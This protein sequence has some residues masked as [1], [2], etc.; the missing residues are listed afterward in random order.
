[1][2]R[3]SR[4]VAP[5]LLALLLGV[6]L[7]PDPGA[8]S[9][10]PSSSLEDGDWSDSDES[11]LDVEEDEEPEWSGRVPTAAELL[12]LDSVEE[13]RTSGGAP[14][15]HEIDLDKLVELCYDGWSNAAMAEELGVRSR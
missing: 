8:S 15:Q 3:A 6:S 2:L 14:V 13:L 1:M 4:R 11:D 7:A 10:T 9:S 12:G 5:L